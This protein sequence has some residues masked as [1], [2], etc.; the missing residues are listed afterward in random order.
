MATWANIVTEVGVWTTRPDLLGETN[1][2]IRQAIR[3]LHRSGRFWRD[4]TV[5]NVTPEAGAFNGTGNQRIDMDAYPFYRQAVYLKYED[6]DTFLKPVDIA[7]LVDQDYFIRDGV[8][9]GMGNYL[10]IRNSDP[11][12]SYELA[13]LKHPNVAGNTSDSWILTQYPDAV[14]L[15]AA[16]IIL[17]A[18]GENEIKAKVEKLAGGEIRN[19]I[20]DNLEIENR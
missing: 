11:Q 20:K 7:D 18:I 13:F 6:S 12:A 10:Q 19:L 8:Y 14:T 1:L 9:W 4:M 5:L 17:N 16:T 15:V 3:N 2:A